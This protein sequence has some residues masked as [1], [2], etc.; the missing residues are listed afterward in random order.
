VRFRAAQSRAGSLTEAIANV[1]AGYV[2]AI[3]VQRIA[4]PLFG[5]TTSLATDSIIAG[6]FTATSL[7]RSYVL[8]RLFEAL[9][10]AGELGT[11]DART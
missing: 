1:V 6:L 11:G 10:E 3:L 8:R 9:G 4:Y 5:I 2:L 7:V